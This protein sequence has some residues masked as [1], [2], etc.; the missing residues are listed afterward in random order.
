MT[1]SLLL[2]IRRPFIRAQPYAMCWRRARAKL[3][4]KVGWWE[5]KSSCRL[6]RCGEIADIEWA[7]REAGPFM[8]WYRSDKP[9]SVRAK[10]T[11]RPSIWDDCYQSP[12]A[13]LHLTFVRDTA[14]H[15]GKDFAVSF[16][17][18]DMHALQESTVP[19][20]TRRFCSHLAHYCGRALPATY[21]PAPVL[22]PREQKLGLG[23]AR[24]FLNTNTLVSYCDRLDRSGISIPHSINFASQTYPHT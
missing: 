16:M 18:R 6:D 14:L 17:P 1:R 24:T 22:E 12:R 23:S 11:R 7:R 4:R 2:P 9:S 5:A 10:G 13:A 15:W 8:C 19:F 21:L 3:A 20:G